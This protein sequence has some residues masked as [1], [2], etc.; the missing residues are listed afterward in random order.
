MAGL[1]SFRLIRQF[2]REFGLTPHAYQLDC[3]I[4]RTR[5][6]LQRGHPLADLA[7]LAGF[8]DQSHFQRAF[9]LRV[10][11]TPVQYRTAAARSNR[12]R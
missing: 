5:A 4:N 9:K 7:C 8:T 12:P 11:A 1:S 2:R 3:R 6:L 10:A